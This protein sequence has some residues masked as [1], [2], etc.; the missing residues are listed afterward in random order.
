MNNDTLSLDRIDLKLFLDDS[1]EV[2]WEGCVQVFTHWLKADPDEEEWLDI[3]DYTHMP[4]GPGVLVIGPEKHVSIDDRRGELGV[5][6]SR[7]EPFSGTNIERLQQLVS[8][9]ARFACLL[10]EADI[11]V[12]VKTDRLE[13]IVNDRLGFPN[14]AE[15]AAA[16][17]A[18]LRAALE[19]A[20]EL[21]FERYES[22]SER[23][24][25]TVRPAE[26]LTAADWADGV[27]E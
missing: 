7:R 9:T 19:S 23:L 8:E 15:T 16:L 21:S 12:K 10:E 20:G 5:L 3:A 11:G 1:V 17:E 25:L 26:P 18:D 14:D 13:F 27:P 4:Q 24:N 2:D 22:P 6:Y